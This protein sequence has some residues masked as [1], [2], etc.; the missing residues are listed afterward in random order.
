VSRLVAEG[1]FVADGATRH[2]PVLHVWMNL[3]PHRD[4][5]PALNVLRFARIEIPKARHI[6]EIEI[7]AAVFAVHLESIAVLAAVGEAGGFEM[8]DRSIDIFADENGCVLDFDFR[9]S[10]LGP[11]ALAHKNPAGSGYRIDIAYQVIRKIHQ[12]RM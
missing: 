11:V 7:H 8:A 6:F 10:A 4:L 5:S 3:F 9:F 2:P 12:M 1:V